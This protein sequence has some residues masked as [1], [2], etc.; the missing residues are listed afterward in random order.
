MQTRRQ[1]PRITGIRVSITMLMLAVVGCSEQQPEDLKPVPGVSP[2]APAPTTEAKGNANASQDLELTLSPTMA[3]RGT[4]DLDKPLRPRDVERQL[5]IALRCAER[6]ELDRAKTLLDRILALEPIHRE[7]LGGRA[8]VALTESEKSDDPEKKLALIEQAGALVRKLFRAYERPNKREL[9]LLVSVNYGEVRANVNL[10]HYDRAVE[11]IEEAHKAGFDPFATVAA[12][13]DLAKLRTQPKYKALVDR[14][15]KERLAKAK[16]RVKDEFDRTPHFAFDLNVTTLEGKKLSL[17][18]LRGKVVL[19]DIW[20]TWCKPCRETIPALILLYQ[21]HRDRGLEIIGLDYEKNAP[22]KQSAEELVKQVV[23]EVGIP[24]P[25]AMGDEA[26]LE[27]IPGFQA[28]PTTLLIDRTGK[29]RLML[30]GGG[31]EAVDTIDAGLEVL[32]A[33]TGSQTGASQATSKS[34]APANT[35]GQNPT[36]K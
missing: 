25:I 35:P 18:Q 24:Y 3:I 30:T 7:A 29:V 28:Y 13:P 23:K 19:I 8:A 10:G 26:I 1:Q 2:F 6:G 4:V 17:D 9:A 5:R 16:T 11:V 22:D 21:K 12:D 20:G 34:D 36:A 33:E 15:A 14:V 31:Q 27:T 32:L